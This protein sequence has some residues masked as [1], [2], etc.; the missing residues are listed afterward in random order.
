MFPSSVINCNQQST[1]IP[2]TV[3]EKLVATHKHNNNVI[4]QH[5][6]LQNIAAIEVYA[7]AKRIISTAPRLRTY[8][9]IVGTY[10]QRGASDRASVQRRRRPPYNKPHRTVF[11]SIL[12]DDSTRTHVRPFIID[13]CCTC[14]CPCRHRPRDRDT[15]CSN[16]RANRT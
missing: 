7:R 13:D 15:S 11:I 5:A 2:V 12:D 16:V 14:P 1:Q 3:L 4:H 10:L 6:K 8:K 9:I